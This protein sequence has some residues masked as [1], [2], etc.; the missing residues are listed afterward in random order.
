[1]PSATL[2][3]LIPLYNEEEFIGTLLERVIAAPLPGGIKKEIIVVDD[4]STDDSATIVAGVADKYPGIVQLIR[5][6]RNRGKGAAIRTAVEH[7]SGEYCLIQDADLE[8]NP[9][10]YAELLAPLTDGIADV[11]FG[12]RFVNS[13]RRRV[14]YYWHSVANHILTTMCNLV[15]DLN[16]T[17]METCY[18]AFRTSLIKTIPIRSSRFGIE[19][20]LTIKA[21]RRR[22]RIYEVPVS[23]E[24]RTYE[25]GKKIGL[26]DAFAAIGVIIRFSL[27]GDLYKDPG[28]EILDSFA[29]A[30]RF[31]RWMADTIRPFLG[32]RILEIGAG[33]GNLTR[34]LA[35]KCKRYVATDIDREHLVRL[36]NALLHRPILE[37]ARC[38]LA[39]PSD[40]L[41]FAGSMDTVVCLN[42]LEHLEDDAAGLRNIHSALSGG[43]RAIILVPSGPELFGQMDAVLRHFRR[44]R[45]EQ[46]RQRLEE[47]GFRVEKILEFNRVSRPGWLLN[48]RVLKRSTIG[49]VQL[50]AFDRLVWLWR[51]IDHLLPWGPTSIIAIARKRDPSN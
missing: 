46:F 21:A 9:A 17:D 35:R 51:R 39:N 34:H 8:Y 25:D 31:N 5:V 43:G 41:P 13:G 28:S 1:M 32:E 50:K 44:Y 30:P 22:A 37:T 36:R 29:S 2:S 24:G 7:A 3:V 10:E 38:D 49:R 40:F 26:K 27:I 20:E 6:T 16:L 48:S 19:P 18:K 12:S 45:K 15:A 33:V 14:L 4:G 11:V 42:V 23:Y 47:A